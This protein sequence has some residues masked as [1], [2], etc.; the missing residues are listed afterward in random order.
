MK[1]A[2]KAFQA[3]GMAKTQDRNGVLIFFSVPSHRF[4][5]LGDKGI[6]E[7]V[8]DDFWETIVKAMQTSFSKG[9]F[10]EGLVNGIRVIGEQLK[11]YFPRRPDDVNELPDDITSSK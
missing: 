2:K 11:T 4:S 8:A 1:V 9:E 6:H 3:L 5:V 10:A 7:R